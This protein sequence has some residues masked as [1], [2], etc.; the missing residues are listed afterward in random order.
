VAFVGGLPFKCASAIKM[1]CFTSLK[2]LFCTDDG[3]VSISP[4]IQLFNVGDLGVVDICF[5][6]GKRKLLAKES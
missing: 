4:V 5:F 3:Q 1:R 2:I 6:R